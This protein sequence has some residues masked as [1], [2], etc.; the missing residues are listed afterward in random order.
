MIFIRIQCETPAIPFFAHSAPASNFTAIQFS[1]EYKSFC[2]TLIQHS[3]SIYVICT[4]S[5]YSGAISSWLLLPM[6][7]L[8]CDNIKIFSPNLC[9]LRGVW[10][11]PVIRKPM[12]DI[13]A[14]KLLWRFSILKLWIGF[15]FI[16][17]SC[18]DFYTF[19]W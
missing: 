7:F 14:F 19:L 12:R 10:R 5:Y 4:F 3:P 17:A 13:I 11:I 15:W 8:I 16:K 1:I 18:K 9:N 6:R 2:N